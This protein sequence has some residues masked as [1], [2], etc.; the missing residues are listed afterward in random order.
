[1]ETVIVDAVSRFRG[2]TS[3]MIDDGVSCRLLIEL[4]VAALGED[5]TNVD[6]GVRFCAK[7][8]RRTV[9]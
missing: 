7:V 6:A 1:V 2:D 4:D 3:T 5:M 9:L 8:G